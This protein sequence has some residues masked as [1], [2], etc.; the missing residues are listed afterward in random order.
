MR[1]DPSISLKPASRGHQGLSTAGGGGR[2]ATQISTYPHPRSPGEVVNN[3]ASQDKSKK[4]P[5]N[6][7]T[8]TQ[9]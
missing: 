2:L 7:M 6:K 9:R 3:S 5:V 4:S 1:Q 8:Y